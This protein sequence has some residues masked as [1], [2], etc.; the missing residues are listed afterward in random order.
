MLIPF[1]PPDTYSL[2]APLIDEPLHNDMLDEPDTALLRHYITST[3]LSI[4]PDAET[5]TLW[6][7]VA[8][9][10]A[11][12]HTFLM[13]G[14]LACA[15]LHLAHLN[16]VQQREHAIRASSHQDRA[17][18]L[19]RSAVANVDW[20][21]CE[22]VFLFSHLLVIYS[23]ASEKQDER[24]LLVQANGQDPLPP[25]LYF[26]RSGCSLLCNVWD[27][28]ESGPV[29]PLASAWEIPK[30][31][32]ASEPEFMM[33][34]LSVIPEQTSPDAWTVEECQI[35]RDAAAVL[36]RAFAC[37]HPSEAF[38]TWDALRVWPMYSSVEFFELLQ[39]WHPGALIL[40]AHYCI[41]L[42]RVEWHWYFEGRATR[43][44]S[45]II[46]RLD[47]RWHCYIQWPLEEICDSQGPVKYS[48]AG[49]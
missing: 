15:G 16:P 5:K 27:R 7:D 2:V 13:H 39:R 28:I 36:G 8:P 42:E 31:M 9:R 21:T 23:W 43:L 11:H 25:W 3:S 29:R 38:T 14:I 33:K 35:Y 26:L 20:D 34:L 41:L 6:Q 32:R 19:F 40:L 10:L 24:L 22:A 18:P 4:A 30:A 37:T 44:I 46:P 48:I 45:T 49:L 47:T 12:R 1:Q 17:M